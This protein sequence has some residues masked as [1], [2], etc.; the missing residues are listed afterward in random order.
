MN[1]TAKGGFQKPQKPPLYTPLLVISRVHNW[2]KPEQPQYSQERY[3]RKVLEN[4][5]TSR[6]HF[7]LPNISNVTQP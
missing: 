3:V 7:L 1:L 5:C 2:G 6:S 4:L